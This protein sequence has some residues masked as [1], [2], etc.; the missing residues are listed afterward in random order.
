[1]RLLDSLELHLEEVDLELLVNVVML[2]FAVHL[3]ITM[4]APVPIVLDCLVQS[5]VG[6][7]RPFEQLQEPVRHGHDH[8]VVVA[9]IIGGCVDLLDPGDIVWPMLLGEPCDATVRELLDPMSGLPHPILDGD[10][11]AW[12]AAVVIEYIPFRAFFGGQSGVVVNKVCPKIFEFFSLGVM[13]PRPLLMILLVFPFSL[14][15]GSDEAAG[16]VGDGVE[17]IRDLDGRGGC[18]G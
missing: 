2:E 10:R 6:H 1:L 8:I 18:A 17:V 5:P 3:D 14:L 15:E 13:F 7:R 11:E 12:T 4:E 16:N 9:V